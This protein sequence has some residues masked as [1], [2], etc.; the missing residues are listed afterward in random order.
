MSFDFPGGNLF[1]Q[2]EK[3]QDQLVDHLFSRGD[4]MKDLFSSLHDKVQTSLT[5]NHEMVGNDLNDIARQL[6]LPSL[7]ID[8]SGSNNSSDNSGSLFPFT[9]PALP[10][11]E[12]A[13][14][15]GSE[16]GLKIGILPPDGAA[17]F[18]A[19]QQHAMER[20]KQLSPEQ[21]QAFNKELDRR[22]TQ[23]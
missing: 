15:D 13:A 9:P 11:L 18:K 21:L 2:I 12:I 23:M 10:R 8:D 6:G 14:D 5:Q 1:K 20:L 3:S 4:Q 19:L 22:A 16:S 7:S 17:V